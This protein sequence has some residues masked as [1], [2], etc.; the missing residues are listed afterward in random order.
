MDIRTIVLG[1]LKNPGPGGRRMGIAGSRRN[2][3]IL[4]CCRSDRRAQGALPA[5]HCR[6]MRSGVGG[7]SSPPGRFGLWS[8]GGLSILI[9]EI[10][11][12]MKRGSIEMSHDFE[13]KKVGLVATIIGVAVLSLGILGLLSN[14]G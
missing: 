10:F 14:L 2:F 7:C 11:T 13:N 6:G 8:D 3:T 9:H 12:G 4:E 1:K 5:K